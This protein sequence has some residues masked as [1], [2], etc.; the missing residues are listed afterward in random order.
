M[1]ASTAAD[2]VVLL[3][4]GSLVGPGWLDRLLAA[5]D[6]DP[7]P[8]LAG[9]STNLA[10]NEQGVFPGSGDTFAQELQITLSP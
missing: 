3:E 1:A 5:L 4:S 9:P 8:G 2:I 10:W 6:A 7:R